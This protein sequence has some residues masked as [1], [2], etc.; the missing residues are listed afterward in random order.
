[1]KPVIGDVHIA[2]LEWP[3]LAGCVSTQS[4]QQADLLPSSLVARVTPIRVCLE[5]AF[6]ANCRRW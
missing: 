2:A 1:L 6:P 5:L 3:E 4:R